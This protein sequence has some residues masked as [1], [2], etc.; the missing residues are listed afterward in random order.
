MKFRFL[1]KCIYKIYIYIYKYI[2]TYI[3]IYRVIKMYVIKMVNI[4]Y[5]LIIFITLPTHS[6]QPL[7]MNIVAI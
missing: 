2:I 6:N 7:Y 4:A 5:H 3:Y 1:I